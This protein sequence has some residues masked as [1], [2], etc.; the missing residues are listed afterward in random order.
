MKD[1]I[2]L[3]LLMLI[4]IGFFLISLSV[5]SYY[6]WLLGVILSI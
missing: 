5:I 1:N 6:V 3:W 2:I 4:G